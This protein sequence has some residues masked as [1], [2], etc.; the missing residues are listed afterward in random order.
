MGDSRTASSAGKPIQRIAVIGAGSWG[1][2]LAVALARNGVRADLWGR[3]R[4]HLRQLSAERQ[5]TRYLP[6]CRFPASLSLQPELA[7]AVRQSDAALVVVPSHAF[8]E[9]L[10]AVAPHLKT[11][12]GVLW[13]TKGLEPDSA[14]LP[15]QVAAEVLPSETPRAVLAGPTFA[16]EVARGLPAGVTVASDNA[17]LAANVVAVLHGGRLRAYTSDDMAGVEIGGAV[18]NVLAIGM[19]ISDGLEFGANARAALLTRG[20]AEM[21]RLGETAGARGATLMGLT[22]LGDL[23]L[24]CTGDLSR[25]RRLGLLLAGGRSTAQAQEEIGQV[26]E[27]VRVSR[28]VRRLAQR[29]SVEMPIS[30]QVYRVLHEGISPRRAVD[31]LMRRPSKPELT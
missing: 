19:G 23:V 9:T 4:A 25:N 12:Q 5:N 28:E 22:G 14:R 13:A 11:G 10:R 16:A 17:D 27:G 1:T 31:A 24:T 21:M 20:L 6:G 30:E 29:A 8:K 15:H 3:S 18:K 7:L 26:V 2:A